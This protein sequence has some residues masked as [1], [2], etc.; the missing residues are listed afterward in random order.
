MT[1][2]V[3]PTTRVYRRHG[4]EADGLRSCPRCTRRLSP[5]AFRRDVRGYFISWCR[6]CEATYKRDWKRARRRTQLASSERTAKETPQ[7]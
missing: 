4:V 1:T 2:S 5:D 3:P 6:H 7:P